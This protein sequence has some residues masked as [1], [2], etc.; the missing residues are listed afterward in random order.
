RTRSTRTKP[1]G[2][3]RQP[4]RYRAAT[5]CPAEPP[6]LATSSFA[7]TGSARTASPGGALLPG[8]TVRPA[9][10]STTS[11]AH[12]VPF[13]LYHEVWLALRSSSRLETCVPPSAVL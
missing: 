13:S 10:L 9:P 8:E 7:P 4:R 11:L 6:A 3:R 1:G 2:R 5:C 12:S